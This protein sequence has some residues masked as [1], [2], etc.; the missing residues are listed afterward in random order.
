MKLAKESSQIWLMA[1]LAYFSAAALTIHLSSNGKDIA[2]IWPANAI[3]VALLLAD[4]RPRWATV[5]TAGFTGGVAANLVMRGTLLGP[6]A[7]GLA[8]AVEIWIAT[9]CLRREKGYDGILQ[10]TPA[11]ARFIVFAGLLAPACSGLLGG[12]TAFYV[13]GEPFLKSFT[14]WLASDGL[15]LVVFTPFFHAAFRGDFIMCFRRKSWLQR[16]ESLALLIFV[17]ATAHWIFYV[18]PY[19][20][21]FVIFLPL[22]LITFRVGRLGAE[23]AVMLIA[24]IGGIATMHGYGPIARAFPGPAMQAQAFQAFLAVTLLICLPVAA[25][26][27]ARSRLTAA[28]AAHGQRMTLSAITDPLTG[29]LNRGGFEAEIHKFASHYNNIPFSLIAID[30]DHFK[31]INDR[32]GHHA[33]DQALKHLNSIIASHVRALDLI[34]RIGGDEFM[35]LL[36]NSNL[37]LA[38][39]VSERIRNAVRTSP[40]EIDDDVVTMITLSMGIAASRPGETYQAIARRAD[41]ALYDAKEAGRNTVRWAA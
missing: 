21:V 37:E 5:L 16:A 13:Y 10:S 11:V 22:M 17:G 15:G 30:L 18:S 40:L 8:N 34:G 3:L 38:K 20:T 25:E 6:I 14:T 31:Q 41:R 1:F 33:G 36:P 7:Y 32:W 23:A 9:S 27:S 39:T 35:I 19:P 29:A 2:T 24:I 12:T 26:V 4:I 28:L